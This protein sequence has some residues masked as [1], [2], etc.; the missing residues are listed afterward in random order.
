MFVLGKIDVILAWDR[1][2]IHERDL[3]FVDLGR[4]L[5]EVRASQYWRFEKMK[6]FDDFLEKQFPDSH[7]KHIT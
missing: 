2:R 1:D 3:R 4:Y 6:S 7:R 5:C